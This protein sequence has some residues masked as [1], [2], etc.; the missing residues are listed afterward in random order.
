MIA[1]RKAAVS[2]IDSLEPIHTAV[3]GSMRRF[4]ALLAIGTGLA[5][6]AQ[7]AAGGP[8]FPVA[9]ETAFI[10]GSFTIQLRAALKRDGVKFISDTMRCKYLGKQRWICFPRYTVERHGEFAKYAVRISVTPNTW[11]TDGRPRVVYNWSRSRPPAPDDAE[12]CLL[13]AAHQ[14]HLGA[15]AV[16]NMP[17]GQV[18]V[19]FVDRR[20]DYVRY[21]VF[22]RHTLSSATGERV[23]GL[24][25]PRNA[26]G[27]A[28]QLPF[29]TR[30]GRHASSSTF[31][32][33]GANVTT[34]IFEFAHGKPV[35]GGVLRGFYEALWQ[36]RAYPD[37]ITL[38][39]KSGSV[40]NVKVP[41]S[42]AK[43]P[44]LNFTGLVNLGK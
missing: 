25:A 12:R 17:G 29:C 43:G 16:A 27:I 13:G 39:T 20:D 6:P 34:A 3:G 28:Y 44:C 36:S 18:E 41:R 33:V 42:L 5:I 19:L 1:L 10:K 21:C 22:E 31:G 30:E 14:A 15:P 26:N 11:R 38:T 24:P 23:S 4:I 9:T 32:R 8:D 2:A 35:S 37:R 7:A 40:V